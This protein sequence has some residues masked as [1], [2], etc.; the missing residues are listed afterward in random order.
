MV[1][2]LN[3]RYALNAANPRWDFLCTARYGIDAISEEDGVARTGAYNPVR[4]HK[5]IELARNFLDT[6]FSLN[7]VSH[8]QAAHYSMVDGDLNGK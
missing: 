7:K 6:H 3:A 5:V 1:P 4:G 8:K 2:V